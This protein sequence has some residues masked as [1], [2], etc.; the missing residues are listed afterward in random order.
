MVTSQ[1]PQPLAFMS[2]V[3]IIRK[4]DGSDVMNVESYVMKATANGIIARIKTRDR[5][6]PCGDYMDMF[7]RCIRAPSILTTV[8]SVFIL[9]G[10]G[11]VSNKAP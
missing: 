4:P 8:V 9:K 11:S 7:Y 3:C 6:F 2:L 10:F 1:L 5:D